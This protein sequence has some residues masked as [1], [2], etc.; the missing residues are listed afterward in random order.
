[1]IKEETARRHLN[2]NVE[3]IYVKDKFE[4]EETG[5]LVEVTPFLIILKLDKFKRLVIYLEHIISISEL[6]KRRIK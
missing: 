6:N 3:V 5:R 1:M 2:K 4:L